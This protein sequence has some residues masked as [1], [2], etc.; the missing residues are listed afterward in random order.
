MNVAFNIKFK[1]VIRRL[2]EGNSQRTFPTFFRQQKV[3]LK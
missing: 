3:M 2:G 1:I